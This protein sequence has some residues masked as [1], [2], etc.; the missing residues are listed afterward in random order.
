MLIQLD[1][2]I[3]EILSHITTSPPIRESKTRYRPRKIGWEKE[4]VDRIKNKLKNINRVLIIDYIFLRFLS[5]L[6]KIYQKN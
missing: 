6:K 5:A 1:K 2:K 4:R 3:H